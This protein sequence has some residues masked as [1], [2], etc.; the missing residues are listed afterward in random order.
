[1]MQLPF[2][3]VVRL[4]VARS[5]GFGCLLCGTDLDDRPVEMIAAQIMG[6]IRALRPPNNY[7]KTL[8]IYVEDVYMEWG[9][10]R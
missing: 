7:P 6:N 5:I 9:R 4:E 8:G 10:R 3:R 1:M 2:L